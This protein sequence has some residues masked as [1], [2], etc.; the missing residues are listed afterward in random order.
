MYACL[1][2]GFVLAEMDFCLQHCVHVCNDGSILL[3]CISVDIIGF[4]VQIW[5]C[6]FTSQ[7]GQCG[8]R[9]CRDR[10]C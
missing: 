5:V 1:R 6:V 2:V 8:V 3:E 10:C 7:I 4:V 9:K